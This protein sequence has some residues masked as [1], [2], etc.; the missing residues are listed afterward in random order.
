MELLGFFEKAKF[1]TRVYK[2]KLVFFF[3]INFM[4][5][6]NKPKLKNHFRLIMY[7]L[8]RLLSRITVY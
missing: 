3:E 6:N 7:M 4:I 2:A 1:W 8:K 5:K